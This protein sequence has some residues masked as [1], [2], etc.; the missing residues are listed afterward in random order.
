MNTHN[1]AAQSA[2]LPA[3]M[4]RPPLVHLVLYILVV[5]LALASFQGAEISFAKFGE[6]I[7]YLWELLTEMFPPD[8]SR[9]GPI[10][11]ALWQTFQMAVVGTILGI[12]VSVPLGICASRVH[13]PH[14]LVFYC[15]RGLI[16]FFRTV[17]DLIWALIFIVSV[18]LGPFAGTLALMIDTM[19]FAGRFFCLLYTSDAADE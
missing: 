16:S 9:I 6:G 18:G 1:I 12:L 19:G 8:L 10:G 14:P 4:S 11:A 3:R 7:P 2:Q 13:S 17:P 5:W 15:A